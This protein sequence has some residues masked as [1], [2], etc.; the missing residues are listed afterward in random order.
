MRR[1]DPEGG[2][3]AGRVPL[4]GGVAKGELACRLFP[5]Y[6]P[7]YARRLLLQNIRRNR[8]LLRDLRRAGWTE[9]SKFLT[10]RQAEIILAVL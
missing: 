4:R 9:R 2:G 5:T 8:A 1:S 10:R 7:E 6:A 3:P